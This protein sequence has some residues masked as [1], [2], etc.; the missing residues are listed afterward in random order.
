MHALR[1]IGLEWAKGMGKVVNTG[2]AAEDGFGQNRSWM[3]TFVLDCL[4][5]SWYAYTVRKEW[6]RACERSFLLP[7]FTLFYYLLL[8]FTKFYLRVRGPADRIILVE[9]CGKE[10]EDTLFFYRIVLYINVQLRTGA[11]RYDERAGKGNGLHWHR[12]RQGRKADRDDCGRG[13]VFS[14]PGVRGIKKRGSRFGEGLDYQGVPWS[15]LNFTFLHY[16]SL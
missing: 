8:F 1:L 3:V 7:L 11:G 12:L 10:R 15:S 5:F 4:W 9:G 2:S 6:R 14:G 16:I 13:K